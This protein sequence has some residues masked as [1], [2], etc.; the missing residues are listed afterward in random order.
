SAFTRVT[1]RTLALPP[2]RGTLIRRL[3][4]YRHLH[5]CSGCFRLERLPGGTCTHW[6]APP[7]HGAHPLLTFSLSTWTPPSLGQSAVSTYLRM[8][9]SLV[10]LGPDSTGVEAVDSAYPRRLVATGL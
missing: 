2:I 3:Q 5:V 6:K 8:V 10:R 4:T 9:G 7:L 1:A